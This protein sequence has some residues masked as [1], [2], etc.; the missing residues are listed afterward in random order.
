MISTQ[1]TS[2]LKILRSFGEI[3]L[4]HF[5]DRLRLQ[6]LGY[7]A[8]N[9]GANEE[10]PFS[11]YV[12]GPY[13]TSLTSIL[14]AGDENGSFDDDVELTTTEKHVVENLKNLLKENTC[15]PSILELYAS[16]WYLTPNKKLSDSDKKHVVDLM[17][18]EKPHF[19]QLQIE[20][21][22]KEIISFRS[23]LN[24]S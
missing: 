11:W 10:F 14:F 17:R 18:K 13:S 3:N 24:Y 2:V 20:N 21:A 4:D 8:Q 7:L 5:D 9:L 22:L 23:K 19:S 12:H 6:K 16:I 15:N 1:N